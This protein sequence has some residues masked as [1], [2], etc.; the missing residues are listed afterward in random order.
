MLLPD[1]ALPVVKGRRLPL[2]GLP[3]RLLLTPQFLPALLFF[4][5]A[6]GAFLLLAEQLL[7]G[8]MR[9]GECKSLIDAGRNPSESPCRGIRGHASMRTFLSLMSLGRLFMMP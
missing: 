3:T 5:L 7:R 6:G 1:L 9:R 8:A 2:Y 4:G